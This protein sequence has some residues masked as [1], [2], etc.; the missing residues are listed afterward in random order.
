MLWSRK[1]P[2]QP[3]V[4][5]VF[6]SGGARGWAHVGV[7][8]ALR[9]LEFKPDLVVGTSIGAVAAAIHATDALAAAERLAEE[10][11][12]RR[13]ATLFFELGLPKSGLVEGRRVMALLG[14]LLP[15][16]PIDGL[17]M[18]F[19][20]VATDLHSHGEVVIAK[21]GL[22]AAIR[23]SI[24]IPG[25]FTPVHREGKWLVDGGLVNPL[26]VSV[27]RAMGATQV[28][29]VDINLLEGADP[30]EPIPA[31]APKKPRSRANTL[32]AWMQ[33]LGGDAPGD[34]EDPNTEKTLRGVLEG[35]LGIHGANRHDAPPSLLE[36]VIRALRAGENAITR[37]RLLR[38]PPN[39]LI[40]P[41]VGHIG[42]LDFHRAS[43]A[44]AAGYAATMAHAD[45][46]R[47]LTR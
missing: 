44:I 15:E 19:A 47:A 25:V 46:L 4:A 39:L 14:E 6:G 43:V 26:P 1:R 38:E 11:D 2:S 35:F 27:A 21:E 30:V 20:A 3:T 24:S 22:L 41:A 32:A 5:L 10:L 45:A 29:A 13:A 12:W 23:A 8:R 37:E 17:P 31:T 16:Q 28:V 36:V 7:L 40:Q 9:E 34:A 42:T 18:P 33:R